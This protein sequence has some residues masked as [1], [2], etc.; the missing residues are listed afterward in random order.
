MKRRVLANKYRTLLNLSSELQFN[1]SPRNS[2]VTEILD[3]LLYDVAGA[4][5]DLKFHRDVARLLPRIEDTFRNC[6]E[7]CSSIQRE[8]SI[9]IEKLDAYLEGEA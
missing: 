6:K 2:E 9:L 4:Q 8:N 1:I 5:R 7:A 3:N